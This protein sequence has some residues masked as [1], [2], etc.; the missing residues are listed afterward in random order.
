MEAGSGRREKI[1]GYGRFNSGKSSMWVA[2]AAWIADTGTDSHLY[3]GDTDDAWSAVQYG[4]IEPVVSAVHITDY[5][6]GLRWARGV[7]E[8]VKKDDWVVWDM[9]DKCW[10]WSQE[11]YFTTVQGDDDLLLADVYVRNQQRAGSMAGDHG[12]NWGVIYKY[13]HGLLNMVLNMPCHVLMVAAAREIRP[14][15]K[16]S[17]QA[18]YKGVGFY[19]AGPPNENE[20]SHNLHTVLYCAET[21]KGWIYTSI[22]EMGPINRPKRKMLKGEDV[23][24]FVSTYLVSVAGWRL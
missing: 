8:M 12:S 4:D 17:I 20:L 16:A 7:R 14:D 10:S 19:P 2:I 9:A 23:V 22:K 18:Q 13:Y 11:H 3:V 15:T 6:E 1:L 21:P 5:V 24:D